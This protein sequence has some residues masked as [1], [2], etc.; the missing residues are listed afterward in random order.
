[1]KKKLIKLIQQ[2]LP[3]E[4][5]LNLNDDVFLIGLMDG[6][7]KFYGFENVGGE[8]MAITRDSPD[9]Y[10]I[11]DMDQADVKYIFDAG[12][13]EKLSTGYYKIEPSN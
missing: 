12:I 7:D 1:M 9:G 4:N 3:H 6:S 13:F 10:P 8:I 2:I 11:T 5:E